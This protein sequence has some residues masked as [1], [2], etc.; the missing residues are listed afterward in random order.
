MVLSIYQEGTKLL[1]GLASKP[2]PEMITREE[3]AKECVFWCN[4]GYRMGYM[5]AKEGGDLTKDEV[6]LSWQ[7]ENGPI[8]E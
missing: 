7:D 2:M 5:V 3:A 6:R 1:L 4:T 8:K